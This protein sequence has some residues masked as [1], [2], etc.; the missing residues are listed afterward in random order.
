MGG[1]EVLEVRKFGGPAKCPPYLYSGILLSE[2]LC[3]LQVEGCRDLDV[4]LVAVDELDAYA[5]ALY[6]GGVIG[7]RL[8]L[9]LV[10]CLL[11]ERDVEDLGR[12]YGAIEV[13]VYGES[14]L[15]PWVG[16]AQRVGDGHHGHRRV[17]LARHLETVG[18]DLLRDERPHPV[19]EP[20]NP[21]FVVG[22]E[23]Q[24]IL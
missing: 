8:P 19:V 22:D 1:L 18:D 16:V 5:E 10:E 13:A 4:L 15:R 12:L 20:D 2:D 24:T 11:G 23:R 21:F 7:E 14:P 6:H 9:R 17:F 3:D